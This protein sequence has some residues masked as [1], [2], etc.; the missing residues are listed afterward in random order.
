MHDLEHWCEHKPQDIHII[1]WN[2][3][4]YLAIDFDTDNHSYEINTMFDIKYCPF[5]GQKLTAAE[6]IWV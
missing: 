1:E 3:N 6:E 4:P 5:C 2:N